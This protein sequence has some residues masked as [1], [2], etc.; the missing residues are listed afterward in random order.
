MERMAVSR[1]L[2]L[3]LIGA[4]LVG[5]TFTATRSARE[6]AGDGDAPTGKQARSVKPPERAKPTRKHAA[7][8]HPRATPR[9]KPAAL[10]RA[11]SRGRTVVLFFF[12][13]GS[14]DDEATAAAVARARGTRGVT[15]VSDRIRNVGRYGPIVGSL[16][17]SQAPAIVIVDRRRQAR[18]VEGFVDPQT[19]AQGI[20]DIR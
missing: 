12:Q 10:G 4:L 1:P 16:G 2:L 5:V 6:S 11:L 18:L 3:V 7:A 20:A 9:G 19:L 13:P 14:L 15:V 8:G 17:V